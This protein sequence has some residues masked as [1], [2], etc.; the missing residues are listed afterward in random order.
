MSHRTNYDLGH[1]SMHAGQIGRLSC[2]S[3]IPIVGGDSM[4][5]NLD[6]VFRLSPL[7]RN[8]TVDCK[9]DLFAFYVPHRQIYGSEWTNMVKEGV[10]TATTLT[11]GPTFSSTQNYLGQPAGWD[12]EPA[13][14][15]P[16]WLIAGYNRI[17]NRYFR[18]P[19]D[20]NE[21]TDIEGLTGNDGKNFGRLCAY[22]KSIWTTPLYAG[23]I[24]AA[25]DREVA[26][27]TVLDLVDLAQTK[28]R[29]K[30]E[31]EL[32]WFTQRYSDIMKRKYGGGANTDA[33]ERPTLLM[34]KSSFMS[35]YDVD[36]TDDA[37][38][39]S[40]SGKAASIQNFNIPRKYF[41]EHGTVYLMS[42]LRFPVIHDTEAH[43]LASIASPTYKEIMGDPTITAEEEPFLAESVEFFPKDGTTA[44]IGYIPFGQ[45]WRTQPS[46]VHSKYDA[47][48]G[49]PFLHQTP[50]TELEATYI[51][52]ADYDPIFQTSQLGHWQSQCRIQVD[53]SRVVPAAVSSIM[54]GA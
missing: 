15:T 21:L 1:Y 32:A 36:G 33:D 30:T 14:A 31:I 16:K 17:W 34:R 46:Y 22:P 47:L 43:Y 28:A 4:S 18:H 48:N 9:I 5:I 23:D 2:L 37:S 35:G 39:G 29:Y 19:S 8:L 40:Y 26:S 6:G 53:A 41:P 10:D 45:W 12:N 54:A 51:S 44:K 24:P 13:V 27:A 52:T 50:T 38:L 11:A 3:V 49:F 7:R 42:L 25:A 20:H